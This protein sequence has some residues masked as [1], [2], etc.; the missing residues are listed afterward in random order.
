VLSLAVIPCSREK[1]WDL[2]PNAGAVRADQA[3]RSAF[4]RLTR[5][6]AEL[7]ADEWVILSAKYGFLKPGDTIAGSYDVTFGRPDDPFISDA[8][9]RRQAVEQWAHVGRV[10]VLCPS[11]YTA[12]VRAAFTGVAIDTPLV[13]VGGWGLMHRWLAEQVTA[14]PK[15]P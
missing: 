4:H 5:Q 13:G 12:R 10:I 9:L 7:H 8:A 3:Y 11:L 2:K 1:V 15:L 6:Y 14:H